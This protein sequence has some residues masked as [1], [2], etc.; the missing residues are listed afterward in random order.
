VRPY[1]SYA[2][3][4]GT[5]I[6][7]SAVAAVLIGLVAGGDL[8]GQSADTR[9]STAV[10]RAVGLEPAAAA[11]VSAAVFSVA[12]GPAAASGVSGAAPSASAGSAGGLN[13]AT[14]ADHVLNGERGAH[15]FYFTRGIYTDF[16]RG[17]SWRT[18]WDTDYPKADQQ[19][20]I[21]LRRLTNLDAYDS[22]NAVALDDPELRRFPFLYMV[23]VGYMDLTPAEVT[24]LRSYLLAGGFAFI[25][26][27]WGT[28]EWRNFEQ[29][30][31][32]VLPEYSIVDLPLDHPFFRSF[33]E[34]TE[35]LQIPSIGTVRR[36][37]GTRTHEQDGWDPQVR[38]IFDDD[39]RLMM[40]INWNTDIGDAWEW[41]E[42][43]DYPLKFSTFAYQMGVNAIVYAM[44]H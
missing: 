6:G 39:G 5:A 30:M 36:Y 9:A 27:F 1:L 26:D 23:E 14:G 20:L 38:A 35:I 33:Y 40:L 32:R 44:S 8:P 17:R 31:Q 15:S 22:E 28:R 37:R 42:Q 7:A 10:V 21:V 3:A 13:G 19:F 11:A 16:G 18:T 41:A 29:Q 4:A 43:P 34:I 12:A 25:D 24:G 2:V